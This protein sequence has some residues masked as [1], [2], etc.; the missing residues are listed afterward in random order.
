MH[1]S[2]SEIN[3]QHSIEV[4]DHID[5]DEPTNFESVAMIYDSN[6]PDHLWLAG[7]Q[8]ASLTGYT[9][10]WVIKVHYNYV[11]SDCSC[12]DK[13][14]I[15]TYRVQNHNNN[16]LHAV[17]F[18]PSDYPREPDPTEFTIDGFWVGATTTV[19][20]VQN[21]FVE[22]NFDLNLE[23]KYEPAPATITY[24]NLVGHVTRFKSIDSC[25]RE[26]PL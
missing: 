19:G 15:R 3:T 16:M 12:K 25:M 13:M 1:L 21:C 6:L 26:S 5:G 22:S 17:L 4:Y 10:N 23:T 8:R 2:W 18:N 7:Y 20:T 11:C 24:T 9:S 14:R